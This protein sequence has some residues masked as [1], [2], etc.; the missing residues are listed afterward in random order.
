MHAQSA[1]K[2]CTTS[3]HYLSFGPRGMFLEH[4]D[5]DQPPLCQAVEQ[6]LK[7][8]QIVVRGT[9]AR[10]YYGRKTSNSNNNKRLQ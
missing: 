5:L 1:L 3:G 10:Q 7:I 2:A 8:R 6:A 9:P 4:M